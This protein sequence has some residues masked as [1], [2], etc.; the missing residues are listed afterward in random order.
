MKGKYIIRDENNDRVVT[1]LTD[2]IVKAFEYASLFQSRSDM[3]AEMAA[4]DFYTFPETFATDR[5]L[6]HMSYLYALEGE[7]MRNMDADFGIVPYPKLDESQEQFKAQIGTSSNVNFLPI[8]CSDPG[9]TCRVLET[10]AYH[11]M[12]DVVP[13][14]YTVALE[15]KYTRDEDVPEMLA[16]IR[17]GMTMNFDFAFSTSPNMGG[18][19]T[20]FMS[21]NGNIASHLKVQT[22]VW[23][24]GIKRLIEGLE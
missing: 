10:L 17:D 11:S 16:L 3:Y 13:T 8:T 19:N 22:K 14:Y 21:A 1:P 15:N 12:L 20:V 4:V 6:F 23:T 18:T 2:R 5:S 7:I 9:L 24:A